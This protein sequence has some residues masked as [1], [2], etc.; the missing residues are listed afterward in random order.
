MTNIKNLVSKSFQ[1]M[2]SPSVLVFVLKIGFS[3]ILLWVVILSVL[4]DVY[5]KIIALYIQKV[6]LIGS[7]EWVQSGGSFFI[8]L[9]VG[10][11]LIIVT[12]SA[13]TSMFSE[14]LLKKLAK[15]HYPNIKAEGT[16]NIAKSL[17]LTIKASVIFFL[18]FLVSF[19]LLFIPILGQV[20][21]LWLWGILIKEPT[22]YDVSSLF[23]I[24]E[25]IL[26][27]KK[28]TSGI[29]AMF[30]SLFNYIPILNIFA[31]VFAQ[32]MFLHSILGKESN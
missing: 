3:S 1:D 18:M 12:M 15:K 20:W 28:Q 6:P 11:M 30:A 2:L 13:F 21:M 25:D 24:D 17:M 26:D 23:I 27:E 31:P 16:P 7:W 10:Y 9:I 29:L 19:P 22:A 8:S 32:I 14:P 5:S 4:W